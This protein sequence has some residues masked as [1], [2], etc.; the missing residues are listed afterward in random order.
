[1]INDFD[2]EIEEIS[3]CISSLHLVLQSLITFSQ[4]NPK[5]GEL[6]IIR[7]KIRGIKILLDSC[8]KTILNKDNSY[9]KIKP[10]LQQQYLEKK[11]KNVKNNE[12]S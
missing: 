12:N 10:I 9:L 3:N 7:S 6:R 4:E 8:Q 11:S 1:M 5:S 2:K